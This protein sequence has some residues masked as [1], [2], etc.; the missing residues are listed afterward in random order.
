MVMIVDIDIGMR[1]SQL[2]VERKK[3]GTASSCRPS[4]FR[5]HR[6]QWACW[7]W[8]R[9]RWE[10]CWGHVGIV[11]AEGGHCKV[12]EAKLGVFVLRRRVS[13]VDECRSGRCRVYNS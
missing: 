7:W 1:Q 11:V 9:A 8:S 10:V 12:V 13:V 2:Q 6:G 3:R 5:W 4:L